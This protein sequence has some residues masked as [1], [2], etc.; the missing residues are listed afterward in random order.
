MIE[1]IKKIVRRQEF[2][3]SVWNTVD[4]LFL[5]FVMLLVTPYFIT[6]LGEEQY[7]IWILVNSIIASIGV[8]NLGIGDAAI[9]FIS[10][11]RAKKD[12]DSIF[13]IINS[14]YSINTALA[15][16]IAS[17]GFVLSAALNKYNFLNL[18]TVNRTLAIDCIRLAAIVFGVKQI[19][20]LF[21]SIF[22]GF[23][24][25]DVSAFMSIISKSI[26]SGGQIIIVVLGYGLVRLFQVSVI[27]SIIVLIFELYFIK[28]KFPRF[29]PFPGLQKQTLRELFSFSGYAWIQSILGILSTQIDKILVVSL[30]GPRFLAYY[31]LASMIGLQIHNFFTA[32]SN[33]IFPRVSVKTESSTSISH[34]YFK[35]QFLILIAGTVV[36]VSLLIFKDLIFGLWLGPEKYKEASELITIFLFNGLFMMITIVPYFTLL[37]SNNIKISTFFMLLNTIL[38][39]SL[40]YAA[41]LHFSV[42]GIA[43][44]KLLSTILSVPIMLVYIHSKI[45][46]SQNGIES[47]LI[48]I[49]VLMVCFAVYF[50]G[51]LSI[52]SI[53]IFL[54][55]LFIL[56]RAKIKLNHYEH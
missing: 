19:E 15:V 4:V 55:F 16:I 27:L 2:A 30:A 47:F 33:W 40:M 38:T 54:I 46:D 13:R 28:Y 5:P 49:P 51:T 17:L 22:K 41:F 18:Q 9:K 10:K 1:T 6:K 3:N 26:L 25:Y 39:Y 43:Y 21:L 36:F 7:G 42:V 8:L 14:A 48:Y 12:E 32:A 35:A 53:I 52:V 45:L 50:S 11:Y 20:Q 24:R 23:E 37:G 34:L 31:G 44:G 56:F 29:N